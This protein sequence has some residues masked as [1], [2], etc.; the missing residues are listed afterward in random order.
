MKK[1]T[2]S[3]GA[4]VMF[5]AAVLAVFTA[6]CKKGPTVESS[7]WGKMPNGQIITKFRIV[8]AGG[9]VMEAL[10]YG[11]RVYRLE[12][13]DRNGKMEDVTIGFSNLEGYAKADPYFGATIGRC[14]NRIAKGEY[15]M[16]GKVHKL[17][18]HSP[19][20]NPVCMVHGGIDSFS[21]RVWKGETFIDG[22]N[23]GIIFTLVSPDGDQL[24]PGTLNATVKYTLTA[25]NVWRIDYTAT[26]DKKTI[27]N[28]TNHVYFNL[29]GAAAGNVGDHWLTI[30]ADE[31]TAVDGNLLP[32]GELMPVK[33]TP[34]DFTSPRRVGERVDSD[35]P[36]IV[37]GKGYDHNFCLRNRSGEMAKAAELYEET[38]G[39]LVEVWTTEPGV[40][41]YG[42][43]FMHG[44]VNEKC[45]K[46][47][48]RR[49]AL[50]LETQHWPDAPNH[51]G[52][53][54][55][56]LAPGQLYR[57]TTEYRFKTR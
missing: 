43:N 1:N 45:G 8:G 18:C 3:A 39:R 10:D 2:F 30:Y 28:L 4:R 5:V 55:I 53:P 27:C 36:Q 49:G 20:R 38:T 12:L 21:H 19:R 31:I 35:H 11:A 34:F 29:R 50:A 33:D 41:F 51:K 14:G 52:F 26:T 6:G 22:D 46:P 56:E 7:E 48:S 25:D 17:Q 24:F 47:L 54:S 40:Q 44:R 16:D 57:T 9:V 42:G 37:C 13:P 32:T 23:A 15:L